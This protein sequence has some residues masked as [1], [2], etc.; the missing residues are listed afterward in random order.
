[1]NP[2]P[3]RWFP[4]FFLALSCGDIQ[5]QSDVT[6]EPFAVVRSSHVYRVIH[7]DTLALDLRIPNAS[8]PQTLGVVFMHGGGFSEGQR[9]RGPHTALLDT[10][11]SFGI[12][13]ASISYRL[14]RKGLGF[15][16]TVSAEDKQATV[17]MAAQDLMFARDWLRSSPIN[18]PE[19]WA[20]A[21]SSAGAEAAL[22][23][24]YGLAPQAWAGIISFAGA[25]AN[26]LEVPQD[27]PPL[28]AAHGIC[29]RVVPSR[30]GI[31]RGCNAE[32]PGAWL[33]CGGICWA[34]R[35]TDSGIGSHSYA[36]CGGGHEIC[37]SAMVD[38]RLQDALVRWLTSL[39]DRHLSSRL[40]HSTKGPF[41]R[42]GQP[43]PQPCH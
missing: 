12:P 38:P 39:D 1:M 25:V 30:E 17:E 35:L 36:Y 5:S 28:F 16:C 3:V 6:A 21:G 9:D 42:E 10:L 18:L 32:D 8:T 43:C 33:L 14:S 34:D 13:S 29:D 22:W 24:G 26:D 4:F 2:Q 15:G 37:N 41:T 40:T 23:A 27:A 19:A 11:A 7:G 20:A 31:H